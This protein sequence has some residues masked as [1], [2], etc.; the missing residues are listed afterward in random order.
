MEPAGRWVPPRFGKLLKLGSTPA[1]LSPKNISPNLIMSDKI[2]INTVDRSPLI[3]GDFNSIY[4][5]VGVVAQ[6][7][8]SNGFSSHTEMHAQKPA[9]SNSPSAQ[10]RADK[11]NDEWML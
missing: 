7:K 6:T 4:L 1:T 5:P 3:P 11:E 9:V 2:M 10:R 8:S